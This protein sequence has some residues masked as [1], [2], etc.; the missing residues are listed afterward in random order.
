ML[1]NFHFKNCRSFYQDS[2]LSME[3]TADTELREINTFSVDDKIMNKG[4]NELLK[5]AIIF[6]SNASGKTNVLKALSYMRNVVLASASQMPIVRGNEPFAFYENAFN[7][8]TLYEVEF[9]QNGVFYKYGFTIQYGAI[10]CEWLDKRTER[11]ANVFKRIGDDITIVGAD[12]LAAKIINLT[13]NTLFLSVGANFNLQIKDMLQSVM[14]WFQNLLI[15]FENNANSLDI[16]NLEHGKY[17]EQALKIL[18]IAD[19]GIQDFSVLKD[20]IVNMADL[21]DVLRFNTQLQTQPPVGQLKQENSNLYNIDVKTAFAIYDSNKKPTNHKK[22][23]L[24]YKNHGFNSEGT[25]RLLCYLGWLLAALDKGMV[26]IIDEL[27]SKLHFLVADYLIKLFNSIDK[28]PR[29]AQLI[30]TAHNVMLMDEDLRRDQIYFT[31]KDK[32]GESSLISLADFKNVR[33]SEL[34]SKRYL[35]GFYAKLPDMT[36][37]L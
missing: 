35:A 9:I 8:E 32:Y 16:Y 24:L 29:N 22:N 21:N 17:K 23:V 3:A 33:K 31:S 20:R 27:D 4:E 26:L 19:I 11:I 15:V 25:E 28:N 2:I 1:V 14:Q 13:P 5:A 30:C 18:T 37:D 12:K 6:G 7:E 36:R 10:T 34:F